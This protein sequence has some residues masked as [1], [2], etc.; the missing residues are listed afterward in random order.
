MGLEIP[1]PDLEFNVEIEHWEH[2]DIDW[3]EFWNVIKGNGPMNHERMK[4]RRKAHDDGRWVR[5]A[6][7]AY[8]RK[9][10]LRSEKA[11]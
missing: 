3:D 7:E 2:G 5:E 6:A 11:S 9:K 4:A 10:K 8:A 1:D